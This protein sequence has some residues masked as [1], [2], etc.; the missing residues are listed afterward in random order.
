VTS[1]HLEKN[2][3]ASRLKGS[4]LFSIGVRASVLRLSL[5]R[6]EE[7]L[8]HGKIATVTIP[9]GEALERGSRD[10]RR[11]TLLRATVSPALNVIYFPYWFIDD[12]RN[13]GLTIV[14][15]VSGAIAERRVPESIVNELAQTSVA[16]GATIGFRPLT[17]P[18]CGWDLHLRANEVATLC[19]K[20]SRAW[21]LEQSELRSVRSSIAEVA[22][23]HAKE[24]ITYLP[25]WVM[26][27]ANQ[28]TFVP[29]FR[30]QNLKVLHQLAANLT[31]NQPKYATGELR[32]GD[33]IG[34]YYDASD[35]KQLAQFLH[36]RKHLNARGE[37]DGPELD[38]GELVLTWIPYRGK[39]AY[40]F[41]PFVGTN[42]Y[43]NQF[44]S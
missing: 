39:G 20:C 25:F 6:P 35:A 31:G 5:F 4:Q 37:V 30:Y 7:L 13:A 1:R 10:M 40:F 28:K 17:C 33:V 42:L 16:T 26:E 14:D 21:Q 41:D 24:L 2:F 27:S 3:I 19:T 23:I 15:A 18:N 36:A 44:V 8:Q 32:S 9:V 22:S 12:E 29:G 34:A 38:L 43:R 11:D